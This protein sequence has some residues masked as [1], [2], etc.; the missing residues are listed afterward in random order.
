[1]A[2][3]DGFFS[4]AA[5]ELDDFYTSTLSLQYTVKSP[6]LAQWNKEKTSL[7]PERGPLFLSLATNLILAD[8]DWLV[9][10]LKGRA[11]A[12]YRLRSKAGNQIFLE[13]EHNLGHRRVK[14]IKKHRKGAYV[15]SPNFCL[16]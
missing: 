2:R 4:Y 12:I 16:I 5:N 9:E 11:N 13:L 14:E 3:D 10:G 1:M 15:C 8:E 6:C 7:P